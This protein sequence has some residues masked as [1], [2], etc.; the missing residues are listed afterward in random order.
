MDK[1]KKLL[2]M[3]NN[4]NLTNEIND[5]VKDKLDYIDPLNIRSIEEKLKETKIE[6]YKELLSGESSKE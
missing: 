6:A 1:T 5:K 3:K 4:A 2:V